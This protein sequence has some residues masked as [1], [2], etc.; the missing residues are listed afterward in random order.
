[1]TDPPPTGDG[2]TPRPSIAEVAAWLRRSAA[3]QRDGEVDEGTEQLAWPP[4]DSGRTDQVE[5]GTGGLAR[6]GATP[7]WA[8]PSPSAEPGEGLHATEPEAGDHG[9]LGGGEPE[10]PGDAV[11]VPTTAPPADP[12]LVDD[13]DGSPVSSAPVDAAAGP[14]PD[15]GLS[16]PR[17]GAPVDEALTDAPASVEEVLADAPAPGGGRPEPQDRLGGERPDEAVPSSAAEPDVG[18]DQAAADLLDRQPEAGPSEQHGA[19][20]GAGLPEPGAGLPEPPL[21]HAP[22]DTPPT[23]RSW[24]RVGPTPV[25]ALGQTGR[26]VVEGAPDL[27][28]AASLMAEPGPA[29]PEVTPADDQSGHDQPGPAVAPPSGGPAAASLFDV[30]L[31]ELANR[32][33]ASALKDQTTSP[34]EADRQDPGSVAATPSTESL[35]VVPPRDESTIA[36]DL[37]QDD[38]KDELLEVDT[39]NTSGTG[40]TSDSEDTEDSGDTSEQDEDEDKDAPVAARRRTRRP[41]RTKYPRGQLREPIGILRRI[42][43]M[44]GVVVVT[45]VLGI[46]AGTAFGAILLFLS[47]AIRN[48]ITSQ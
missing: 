27:A 36:F 46:A 7:S 3:K 17:R 12:E 5:A 41:T 10:E 20:P 22:A 9:Q 16:T 23:A 42:R 40:D 31:V 8:G 44:L 1:M 25:G 28:P 32:A 2:P 18:S 14:P 19:A 15:A 30:N 33:R 24:D 35:A 13:G 6:S 4:A 39:E 26:R 21:A 45:V 34:I 29:R 43:A 37:L 38:D 47:F 48:A 11:G